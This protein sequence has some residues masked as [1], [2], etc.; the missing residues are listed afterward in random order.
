VKVEKWKE[1]LLVDVIAFAKGK[2]VEARA[3][4]PVVTFDHKD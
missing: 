2:K 3:Y 1:I 4:V